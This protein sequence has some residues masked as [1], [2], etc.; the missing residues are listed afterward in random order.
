MDSEPERILVVDDD[1][2]LL[3]LMQ[4]YL[5]R[6]GYRV[7]VCRSAAEAWDRIRAGGQPFRSAIVDL[8]LPGV[9]GEELVL[10]ILAADASIRMVVM[11]GYL[12]GPGQIHDLDESR[13]RY[14]HKP[15]AP[16]ELADAVRG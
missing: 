5:S 4:T 7:D 10:S 3:K 16:K 12:A 9:R 14:L 8:N 11:S 15:F 1:S 6:L 13:V 2:A